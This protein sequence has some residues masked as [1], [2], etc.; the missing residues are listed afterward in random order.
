MPPAENPHIEHNAKKLAASAAV[1]P[2]QLS[3]MCRQSLFESVLSGDPVSQDDIARAGVLFKRMAHASMPADLVA[4]YV[5]ERCGSGTLPDVT[6]DCS[7]MLP[8]PSWH[9]DDAAYTDDSS[10]RKA[11]RSMF[12][13][14]EIFDALAFMH[15]NPELPTGLFVYQHLLLE[16]LDGVR[17]AIAE[18]NAHAGEEFNAFRNEWDAVNFTRMLGPA[19]FVAAQTKRPNSKLSH[20]DIGQPDVIAAFTLLSE[21]GAFERVIRKER[22]MSAQRPDAEDIVIRCPAHGM[23]RKLLVEHET[24]PN[25]FTAVVQNRNAMQPSL[26]AARER[27]AFVQ[28]GIDQGGF[29]WWDSFTRNNQQARVAQRETIP[30]T[31]PAGA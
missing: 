11:R 7:A 22:L 24:V 3:E 23:L 29:F 25:V 19:L 13:Y 15:E 21:S 12:T 1:R 27:I 16:Y 18:T 28:R 5:A 14:R 4:S 8:V 30:H 17:A 26:A 10:A 31:A 9:H 6:A 2:M 20:A